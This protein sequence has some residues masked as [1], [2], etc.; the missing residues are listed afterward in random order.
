VVAGVDEVTAAPAVTDSPSIIDK[1]LDD[2][3]IILFLN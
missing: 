3:E 2:T 1:D